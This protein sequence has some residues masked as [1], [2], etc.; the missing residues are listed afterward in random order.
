VG[1]IRSCAVF[2][3]LQ[4]LGTRVD[5]SRCLGGL[6]CTSPIVHRG[7]NPRR[8]G[9]N[10]AGFSLG[11]WTP[12]VNRQKFSPNESG[13]GHTTRSLGAKIIYRRSAEMILPSLGGAPPG[14]PDVV[15]RGRGG[16]RLAGPN[17]IG[18]CGRS[19]SIKVLM[20]H[21]WPL[22]SLPVPCWFATPAL[23][24]AAMAFDFGWTCCC[25]WKEGALRS[26][27]SANRC[28][29]YAMCSNAAHAGFVVNTCAIS[30]HCWA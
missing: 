2:G 7:R 3:C 21:H 14:R 4:N 30:K 13:L 16:P 27:W 6:F 24:W 29:P 26:C 12:R 17:L 5:G 1:R 25:C 23:L 10:A 20:L 9:S 19:D 18:N 8:Y 28:H 11:F 22:E 15:P